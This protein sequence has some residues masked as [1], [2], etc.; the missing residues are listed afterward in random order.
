MNAYVWQNAL[1]LWT[2]KLLRAF[3]KAHFQQFRYIKKSN[4]FNILAHIGLYLLCFYGSSNSS[5]LSKRILKMKM[6][7]I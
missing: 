7:V 3:H 1:I 6:Y 4:Y 5:Q 2:A